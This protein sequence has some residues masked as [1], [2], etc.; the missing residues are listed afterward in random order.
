M[1]AEFDSFIE[2]IEEAIK[3]EEN[4]C[5]AKVEPG[6]FSQLLKYKPGAED[7]GAFPPPSIWLIDM[8][9]VLFG[10]GGVKGDAMRKADLSV[11]DGVAFSSGPSGHQGEK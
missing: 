9:R 6:P 3:L 4:R 8:Y 7:A 1:P 11:Y 2:G 10:L 5:K